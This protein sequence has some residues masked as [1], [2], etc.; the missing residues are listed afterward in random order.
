M[1]L[2][3]PYTYPQD[4]ISSL[5]R[6]IRA[7][8]GEIP[9]DLVLKDGKII[10]TYTGVVQECDIA[11]FEGCIVG[12]GYG[13]RGMEEINLKGRW[14]A[15]GLIDGHIHVES[16]MLL[17]SR[18]AAALLP[19]GTTAIISDPH[20]IANVM[21][22]K[23]IQLMIQ[24]SENIPFDIFFMAPSCVP[25]TPLESSGA[26]LGPLDLLKLKREPRIL[27][28][29]EMMNFPGVLSGIPEVLEKLVLFENGI[30]DGHGPSLTGRDLQAYFSAGIRSDH[31]TCDP[32]EGREKINC[33]MMLM[34]REGT[35]AKNMDQ[36]LS[37]VTREN[38]RRCCIVS[39]DLHP[40]DILRRGHL[41]FALRRAV[42][43][44]LDP[45]IAVQMVTLNPSEYFGLKDRGALAPG[46]KADMV[47][48]EDLERFVVERVYKDG[49]LVSQGGELADFRLREMDVYSW[50]SMRVLPLTPDH[51]RVPIKGKLARIIELIP[52]QILTRARYEKVRDQDGYIVADPERDILK[53]A[54]VERHRATGSMGI[55]LVKGFGMKKG[56]LASSVAH[57]SHNII[58]VGVDERSLHRAVEEV[59]SM[60]GGMV[61]VDRD[62]VLARVPLEV[63]GLM[64]KEPLELLVYQL[65]ELNRAACGLGCILQHPFMDL[66]FLAL[67]VIPEL[68]LTAMGLVDV[69]RPGLV[70][71]FVD[72]N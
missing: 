14:I 65:E 8:R 2:D 22:M 50:C 46:L 39:D 13:Y 29:A 53:L 69:K 31:E 34:I 59:R 37:L 62:Q 21:G 33:G 41:E 16:S 42:E 43:W 63:A 30:I 56:A 47:V 25:A 5:Q 26:R 11:V 51:F 67:P 3:I 48:F 6:R 18:L 12:I 72:E 9:S 7:A 60:G 55:G 64:S 1:G 52:G 15:P 66:S 20:E 38:S 10:N 19:H 24:E 61:A 70:P 71:L 35:S 57:D 28:L 68:K 54:V 27:G 44:G 4:Q 58:A 49:H 36:L 17:P 32:L 23:G 45:L 40:W